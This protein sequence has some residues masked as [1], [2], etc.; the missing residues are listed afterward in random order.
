ML[1]PGGVEPGRFFGDAD[2]LHQHRWYR[3][4]PSVLD[5]ASADRRAHPKITSKTEP[6]LKNGSLTVGKAIR[7]ASGR[8]QTIGDFVLSRNRQRMRL[9]G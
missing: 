2:A 5:E 3:M 6:A 7:Q 9:E 1:P 4:A 8:Y